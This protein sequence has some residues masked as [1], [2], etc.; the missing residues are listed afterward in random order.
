M[1]AS[2]EDCKA[3][4]VVNE[5]GLAAVC[6]FQ[7]RLWRPIHL[8]SIEEVCFLS[9]KFLILR[10]GESGKLHLISLAQAELHA[11]TIPLQANLDFFACSS[12]GSLIA[13]VG[14]GLH[15]F[16]FTALPSQRQIHFT[17]A[18]T[19][20]LPEDERLVQAATQS[21]LLYLLNSK[22][23]LS[24][25][26]MNTGELTAQLPGISSF[27]CFGDFLLVKQGTW[28]LY[29]NSRLFDLSTTADAI[30]PQLP[31]IVAIASETPNFSLSASLNSTFL[32]PKLFHFTAQLRLLERSKEDELVLEYLLIECL[33]E[34]ELLRQLDEF[35]CGSL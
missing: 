14:E 3:L 26:T 10:T 20:R 22:G 9:N 2:S 27:L 6:D 25:L 29:W 12:D 32:L 23:L 35:F 18:F 1:V 21:G 30:Y 5:E 19:C 8:S 17:N 7:R 16:A 4:V 11:T 13:Q 28:H 33:E 24:I 34:A 15:V 31:G